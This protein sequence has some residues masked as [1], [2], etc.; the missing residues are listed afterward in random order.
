MIKRKDPPAPA[1]AKSEPQ[2]DGNLPVHTIRQRN[3][4][5]AI[6]KNDTDKGVIYNVTLTRSYRDDGGAWHDSQS[7]S[8]GDL[9]N[10][11]KLLFDAHSFITEL[12]MKDAQHETRPAARS[13]KP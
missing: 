8:Y 4:K 9:M 2:P 3:L 6:W 5:A 13:G 7:F 1:S 12:L 11:A 10:V